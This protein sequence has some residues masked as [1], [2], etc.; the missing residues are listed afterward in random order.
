MAIEAA[1]LAPAKFAE[2]MCSHQHHDPKFGH[3]YNYHSRSDAH[4][5][6]LCQLIMDDLLEA[7]PVLRE[8]GAAGKVAYGINAEFKW[9]LSQKTKTIDL[10][11]GIPSSATIL[12]DGNIRRAERFSEV[13]IS[14]EAKAVMTEHKKSQPRLF[15]ELGS[16]HQIVH[17][18]RQDAIA[19][20]ITVLNIAP[21]FV[22]PLRNQRSETPLQVTIHR[23]PA[24]AA[25]M[26][27]HL[28]GL[29]LREDVGS[30]GFDAYCTVVVNCDNQ[31][32]CSLHTETPAP[33]PGDPDHY[34]TF[35]RRIADFYTAR[36]SNL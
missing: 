35:V 21:T 31:T 32:G 9:A 15:D 26:R 19:A 33:Q 14:C 23:Q 10:A 22:S 24:V 12:I 13:F 25:S 34:N 16:S 30:V 2:W 8:Q 3:F 27:T 29:P 18:G 36:F 5:I 1:A 4:S 11:V 28:L 7:C 6:V 17:Q 20:G